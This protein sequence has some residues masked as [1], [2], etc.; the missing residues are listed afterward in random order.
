MGS[1]V[2]P[3][4]WGLKLFL[5]E[6][7]VTDSVL[8]DWIA[9]RWQ[10]GY[11][12]LLATSRDLLFGQLADGVDSCI[13]PRFAPPSSSMNL[14][15]EYTT[16]TTVEGLVC[17]ETCL[18]KN[19]SPKEHRLQTNL[20]VSSSTWLSNLVPKI[21][22]KVTSKLKPYWWENQAGERTK[23]KKLLQKTVQNLH[24]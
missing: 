2:I 21:H 14:A 13:D 19:Q 20:N 8:D 9:I 5:M 22:L 1:K 3:L 11:V 15:R 17:L 16:Q 23:Q 7:D 18:K 12:L 24:L 10:L 4:L 6:A